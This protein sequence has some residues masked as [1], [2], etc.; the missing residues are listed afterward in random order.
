MRQTKNKQIDDLTQKPN[1][2]FNFI[3]LAKNILL[4]IMNL[5]NKGRLKKIYNTIYGFLLKTVKIFVYL[6]LLFIALYA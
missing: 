4:I 2:H 5:F 3:E 6:I 1:L